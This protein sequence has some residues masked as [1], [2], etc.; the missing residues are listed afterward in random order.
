V[1]ALFFESQ[2]CPPEGCPIQEILSVVFEF[3]TIFTKE[4][5]KS[6][7]AKITESEIRDA[8]FSMKNGKILGPDGF[9]IEFFNTFLRPNQERSPKISY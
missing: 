2:F 8:L 7:E 5:N 1:G 4:M 3:P 6:M 9:T